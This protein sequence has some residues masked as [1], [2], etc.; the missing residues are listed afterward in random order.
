MFDFELLHREVLWVA[1]CQP[2][3]NAERGCR[4]QAVCLR[5]RDSFASELPA[6]VAGADSL[7]TSDRRDVQAT[8]ETRGQLSLVIAYASHDLLN[9]HSAY[10][11]ELSGVMQTSQSR[12]GSAAAQS[13]DEDGRIQ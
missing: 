5:Q 12:G 11:R 6:P 1:G 3:A 10:P 2:C 13:I 9:V 4:D 8:Q 7:R